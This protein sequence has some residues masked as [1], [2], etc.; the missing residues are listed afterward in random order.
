MKNRAD[1]NQIID[2]V[3]SCIGEKELIERLSEVG[4]AF[5]RINDVAALR[6]HPQAQFRRVQ[7][8]KGQVTMLGRG[9][10]KELSTEK[11]LQIP[12]LNEHGEKIR[13]EF[14]S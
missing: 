3:F 10:R 14:S 13:A 12:D 9:A 8:K 7:T 6:N 11:M 1:L 4:V 5:G 2:G